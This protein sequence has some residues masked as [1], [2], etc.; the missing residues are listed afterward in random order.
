MACSW[1]FW[2]W[3]ELD[4]KGN[5]P[6][7]DST[8]IAPGHLLVSWS[9]VNTVAPDSANQPDSQ[10]QKTR[11]KPWN[12]LCEMVCSLVAPLEQVVVTLGGHDSLYILEHSIRHTRKPKPWEGKRPSKLL[13]SVSVWTEIR[14]LS[15][16]VLIPL[17]IHYTTCGM[18]TE[19]HP[20]IPK[21]MLYS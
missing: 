16:C 7:K 14:T 6:S 13:S 2:L 5:V 21:F 10:G 1:P 11:G 17:R 15:F 20:P 4:H 19:R 12:M 8:P 3:M 18:I 9:S